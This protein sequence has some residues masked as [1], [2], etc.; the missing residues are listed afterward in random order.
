MRWMLPGLAA[1][2]LMGACDPAA[3]MA[4]EEPG[5]TGGWST[6]GCAVRRSAVTTGGR[7]VQDTPPSSL[8]AAMTLIDRGGRSR[9]AD[10]YAGLEVDQRHVRAVVYRVPSVGFDDFVRRSA[11][12]ACVVVLDCGHALAEL[13]Q[14]RDRIMADR[15]TWADRAVRIS[16]VDER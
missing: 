8:T 1:F 15:P 11:Q 4:H 2:A 13:T 14:W 16:A 5:L 7:A 6:A 12:D 9:Y 3:R 10:S